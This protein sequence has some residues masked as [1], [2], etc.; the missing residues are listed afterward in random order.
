[1]EIVPKH[2]PHPHF[3][4]PYPN[5][6]FK[7][8]RKK[9]S[10]R[11]NCWRW[12]V[13]SAIGFKWNMFYPRL[14][15]FY[16]M[17]LLLALYTSFVFLCVTNRVS[18]W[19]WVWTAHVCALDCC[20]C[21]YCCC[22][23]CLVPGFNWALCFTFHLAITR[24][25]LNSTCEILTTTIIF[26]SNLLLILQFC[27]Y[28]SAILSIAVCLFLARQHSLCTNKDISNHSRC[29]SVDSKSFT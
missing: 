12:I 13:F 25:L 7:S 29:L 5:S 3:H 23:S 22:C 16:F 24:I 21:C 8:S 4:R 17:L 9:R 14:F 15:A 1:M 20:W 18:V 10:K 11:K 6:R 19:V 2:H 28:F 26:G 27:S